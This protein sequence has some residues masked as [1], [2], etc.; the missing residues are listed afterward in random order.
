VDVNSDGVNDLVSFQSDGFYAWISNGTGFATVVQWSPAS[1]DRR[2]RAI[3]DVNGDGYVDFIS[4]QTDGLWVWF[5][6][7][8]GLIQAP[9]RIST[10]NWNRDHAVADMNGDTKSDF[11]SFQSDGL[12]VWPITY[13]ISDNLINITNGVG[14]V[15][16]VA[17]KPL[18]NTTVYTR[19]TGAAYPEVDIQP[20]LWVVS[21][22]AVSN[23]L[24]G[25]SL[26]TYIYRGLRANP[27]QRD[28]SGFRSVERVNT[29]Q[30]QKTIT[31]YR[32]DHPFRSLEEK[33]EVRLTNGTLIGSREDQWNAIAQPSGGD[34][35][36]VSRSTERSF[37]LNGSL[38]SNTVTEKSID[39]FGNA[40]TT[41]TV[42]SDSSSE[43]TVNTFTNDPNTWWIG[44]LT[45]TQTTKSS[46][47]TGIPSTTRTSR[48]QYDSTTRLVTEER[49]EP[50]NPSMEL[51]TAYTYD[52]FGN[53]LTT[54][55]NGVG[56]QTRT[57]SNT[58]DPSGRSVIRTT[59]ALNQVVEM[60]NADPFG[61]M[62]SSTDPNGVPL[63]YSFDPFGRKS[64][65][66][67]P[68]GTVTRA[69]YLKAGVGPL[70]LPRITCAP[71]TLD[72][73][74]HSHT[75]TF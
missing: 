7:G 42:R 74:L 26:N 59:N 10:A 45:Q 52:L 56:V 9:A 15:I 32:Q 5:S 11:I 28:L 53:V 51:V 13:G 61:G 30:G 17:Y 50:G 6:N 64:F 8:T 35:L 73:Y 21:D 18:T 27:Q 37:D 67:F 29:E 70:P 4:F 68:D 65:T 3:A 71:I 31:Y 48:F 63:Q 38:F 19:G 55:I 57:T 25:V 72:R 12:W 66:Y 39:S 43:Q 60:E 58:Y 20:P 1:W 24:G 2:D 44:K 22:V 14:K 41:T 23:G 54:S 69:L 49:I 33:Q 75:M 34:L 40:T 47:T 46:A 62:T 16:S 36:Y